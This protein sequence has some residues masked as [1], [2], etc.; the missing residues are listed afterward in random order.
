VR[1]SMEHEPLNPHVVVVPRWST[2]QANLVGANQGW[3]VTTPCPWHVDRTRAGCTP[4]CPIYVLVMAARY[5]YIRCV[6]GC[7]I[8]SRARI[9]R[10]GNMIECE[11]I[12][13]FLG[14][15]KL[16][17]GRRQA[18]LL[19]VPEQRRLSPYGPHRTRPGSLPATRLPPHRPGRVPRL[20]ARLAVS[21]A[22]MPS[23]SSH[24]A[25]A[26]IG[27]FRCAQS[28]ITMELA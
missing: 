21:V 27:T 15:L 19:P 5:A 3:R 2:S 23:P 18:L 4:H 9:P 26:G 25:S 13:G 12:D 10:T 14:G 8:W 11:V 7:P 6:R 22:A 20:C 24:S 1:R 17:R 16:Q 28:G